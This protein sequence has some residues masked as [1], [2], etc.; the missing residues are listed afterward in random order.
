MKTSIIRQLCI[1]LSLTPAA[2]RHTSPDNGGSKIASDSVSNMDFYE[3]LAS[4][5]DN[6]DGIQDFWTYCFRAPFGGSAAGKLGE[7]VT[8][9]RAAAAARAN[10]LSCAIDTSRTGSDTASHAPA[11][12][13]DGLDFYE[14]VAGGA[15]ECTTITQLMDD[16]SKAPYGPWGDGKAGKLGDPVTSCRAAVTARA[17]VMS[18]SI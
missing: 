18:C 15:E 2:C 13:C 12:G 5:Q 10:A 3:Y 14:C 6:C 1:V 8:S 17:K 16:C 9:C 4:G 11:K 7:P